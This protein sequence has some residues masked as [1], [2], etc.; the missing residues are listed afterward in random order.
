M[1]ANDGGKGYKPPEKFSDPDLVDRIFEYML[2]LKPDMGGAWVEELKQTVRQEF[3]GEKVYVRT[4]WERQQAEL[5]DQV[6]R[7]FNGRNATEVARVLR[8]GRATVY[9]IIKRAGRPKE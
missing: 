4:E 5:A 7:I 3:A 2:E 1:A 8:I 6:L 9:R